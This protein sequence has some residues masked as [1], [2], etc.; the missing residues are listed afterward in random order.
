[1]PWYS[2]LEPEKPVILPGS[3]SKIGLW[4][5]GASDWGRVVYFLRDS[6]GE[7]WISIGRKNSWNCDDIHGW[8][9]FNFDGWRYLRFEL[10]S[11]AP[12]DCYRENGTT[13]WGYYPFG[14]GIVDLPLT[15]EKIIIERRTK[16]MYVNS[17]EPTDT[18][19]VLLADI[20]VEY[21][22]VE[23]A[24]TEAIRLSRLRMPVP[25]GIPGL[26]NPIKKM[27]ETGV[28][29]PTEITNIDLPVQ[30]A[31]GTRC[32]VHFRPA[33]SAVSYDIWVSSYPDGTGAMQLGKQ[34]K[35]P[36]QVLSG[37]RPDVELYL[38]VTYTDKDGKTSK[39][40][41]PF[42]IKLQDIFPFK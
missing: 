35:Q 42:K 39:P 21:L 17:S 4:V 5:K 8:S 34:W 38:F 27:M 7:Q 37:L 11:N 41:K 3:P 13:W 29:E 26:E 23:D 33:E 1:M 18:S 31:D 14:D 10:P 16:A 32:I 22:K 20:Y 36:G 9:Y 24:S 15:L 19:D 6:K 12:Y 28:L 30:L 40:S 25:E 2:I